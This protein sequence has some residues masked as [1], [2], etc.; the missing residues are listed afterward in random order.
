MM[1]FGSLGSPAIVMLLNCASGAG[2]RRVLDQCCA[3][4]DKRPARAFL[5]CDDS[6]LKRI[7]SHV[8]VDRAQG[9][10]RPALSFSSSRGPSCMAR[11]SYA[12]L[13][14]RRVVF[15]SLL[16]QGYL[17]RS[18]EHRRRACARRGRLSA[19]FIDD[20]TLGR[21]GA[22][23]RSAGLRHRH[24]RVVEKRNWSR[25]SSLSTIPPLRQR[26]L[27]ALVPRAT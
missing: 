7:V 10:G 9:C 16:A 25:C 21:S 11:L 22:A 27:R 15:M 1:G 17:N 6:K 23:D 19:R 18:A 8:T 4:L 14:G 5:P 3:T 2:P 12:S 13:A 26:A 20:E 24:A